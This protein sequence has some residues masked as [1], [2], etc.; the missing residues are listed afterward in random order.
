MLKYNKIQITIVVRAT[1]I[2]YLKNSY[3]TRLKINPLRKNLF[4]GITL[5]K[6]IDMNVVPEVET[7]I[8]RL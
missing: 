5:D 8:N 6:S 2:V 7:S 1:I 4:K 3:K